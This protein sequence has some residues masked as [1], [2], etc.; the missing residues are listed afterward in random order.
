MCYRRKVP[1]WLW[2]VT[3]A[4]AGATLLC[5]FA[6]RFFRGNDDGG[7]EEPP[8]FQV[9]KGT[10]VAIHCGRNSG[11]GVVVRRGN[12]IFVWTM[13]F[14][15]E[16]RKTK[17]GTSWTEVCATA[18]V[19]DAAG[20]AH[21]ADVLRYGGHDGPALLRVHRAQLDIFPSSATFALGYIPPWRTPAFSASPSGICGGT[22][23]E[24]SYHIGGYFYDVIRTEDPGNLPTGGGI[25]RADGQ[26]IGIL[27]EKSS[28]KGS[29]VL[30]VRE[31]ER[32]AR[33]NAV[34]WAINS[35]IPVEIPETK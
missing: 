4:A 30:P 24:K 25:F 3:A 13:G 11:A 26:C 34:E 28:P 33:E 21:A 35:A 31:M 20:A 16:E 2:Y 27:I 14:L 18:H 5:V 10:V 17:P 19:H 7:V 29:C 23:L 12:D 6:L 32:W 1:T 15:V 22:Y 9:P 8:A